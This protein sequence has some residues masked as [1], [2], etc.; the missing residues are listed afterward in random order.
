[1]GNRSVGDKGGFDKMVRE[2][3]FPVYPLLAADFMQKSGITEGT[4]LDIGAGNGYLG[5][6]LAEKSNLRVHLVDPDPDILKLAR[7][8]IGER[9]L[10]GRVGTVVAGAGAL[11]FP[12][13]YARLIVSR[14]SVFFWENKVEDFNEIYRVLA[15][16]GW[17]FIGGGFATPQLMA[18]IVAKMK[19]KNPHFDKFVEKNIGPGAPERFH[20]VLR[21]SKVP[22]SEAGVSYDSANLWVIMRKGD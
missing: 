2:I 13:N 19:T 3:M 18:D 4:C 6:A 1:L 9:R 17:T 21:K 8:N 12:D 5:L 11:P 14:G 20:E 10:E 7:V 22:E 16:G 15:P